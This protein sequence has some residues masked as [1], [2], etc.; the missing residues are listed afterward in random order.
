MERLITKGTIRFSRVTTN[1]DPGFYFIV[2]IDDETSGCRLASV[3]IPPDQIGHFF[4]NMLATAEIETYNN[5]HK[6]GKKL[7][8]EDILV[9]LSKFKKY[10]YQEEPKLKTDIINYLKKE[11]PEW[12]PFGI[13]PNNYKKID[14]DQLRVTLRKW[15]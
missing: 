2:E 10:S 13:D 7:V 14:N 3:S 9:D 11:Y 1:K 8:D 15:I 12:E 4:G 6:L 5:Q